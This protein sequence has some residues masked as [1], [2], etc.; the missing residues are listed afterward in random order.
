MKE[1][2]IVPLEFTVI[3]Y[4]YHENDLYCEVTFNVP[5]REAIYKRMMQQAYGEAGNTITKIRRI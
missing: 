5:S 2:T 4:K 3:Q 1:D